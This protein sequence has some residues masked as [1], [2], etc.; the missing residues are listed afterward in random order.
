MTDTKKPAILFLCYS[1]PEANELQRTLGGSVLT[2][3]AE[4][5]KDLVQKFR[6]G[7]ISI[8]YITGQYHSV[9]YNMQ[10]D[11]VSIVETTAFSTLEHE[12]TKLQTRAR[13]LRDPLAK[14]KSLFVKGHTVDAD[15]TDP[16]D[17]NERLMRSM[18][19]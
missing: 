18:D 16:F 17:L 14:N 3:D 9:G 12:P 11:N 2:K 19:T 5:N 7:K 15:F 8:L 10:R 4:A 6:D 1:I 13:V